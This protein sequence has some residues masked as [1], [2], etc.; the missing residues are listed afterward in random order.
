[1]PLIAAGTLVLEHGVCGP[2]WIETS[3]DRIV[4]CAAGAPPHSADVDLP[5]AV[6]V[7]GF[8]DIHVHG[9]GGAT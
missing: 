9:G 2:G 1:M 5:D 7:P 8:V 4:G 6:I 3:G